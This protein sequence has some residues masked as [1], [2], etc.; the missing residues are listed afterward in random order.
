LKTALAFLN[1]SFAIVTA[2][3]GGSAPE[4]CTPT[5]SEIHFRIKTYCTYNY[6]TGVLVNYVGSVF[7]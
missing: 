3:V 2:A 6:N 1:D 4:L 7:E 5:G